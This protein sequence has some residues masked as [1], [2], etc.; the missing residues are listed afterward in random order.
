MSKTCLSHAW[1]RRWYS[2]QN[3]GWPVV[4]LHI[5][6]KTCHLQ[7]TGQLKNHSIF[8]KLLSSSERFCYLKGLGDL[9]SAKTPHGAPFREKA[10]CLWGRNS[11]KISIS[12]WLSQPVSLCKATARSLRICFALA[13]NYRDLYL[14]YTDHTF[15][16]LCMLHVITASIHKK[17]QNLPK[18]AP[19]NHN[20][21]QVS[22]PT[23]VK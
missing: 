17:S 9:T 6:N 22:V 2:Q 5:S 21:H 8:P 7:T 4:P 12:H 23:G 3:S 13:I 15:P 16:L 1:L 18:V 20:V 11:N 10:T 19:S 14:I